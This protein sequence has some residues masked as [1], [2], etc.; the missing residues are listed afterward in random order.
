MPNTTLSMW[1]I[2]IEIFNSGSRK[3]ASAEE[4]LAKFAAEIHSSSAVVP[5]QLDLT[6]AASI[7]AAHAFVADF[8]QKKGI[9]SLDVLVNK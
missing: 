4:A 9:S 1:M 5:V 3:I 2:L 6:D 8:L 7:K